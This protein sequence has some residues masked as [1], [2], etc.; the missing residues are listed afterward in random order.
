MIVII[1]YELPT[2]CGKNLRVRGCEATFPHKKNY[3]DLDSTHREL[4]FLSS[5]ASELA[6][7]N[8]KKVRAS[9]G[10]SGNF[11]T[12]EQKNQ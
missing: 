2:F 8:S 3:A 9:W 12:W 7:L 11:G 4:H 1:I 10:N 5:Y 6:K